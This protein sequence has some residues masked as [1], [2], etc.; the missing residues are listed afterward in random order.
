MKHKIAWW[1]TRLTPTDL[2]DPAT[3]EPLYVY[4][5][6]RPRWYWHWKRF[7]LFAAI[8]WRKW[9]DVRLTAKMAW[10]IAAGVYSDKIQQTP[11]KGAGR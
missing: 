6:I 7:T 4:A 11:T 10:D 8:V 1:T 5:K 9:E 3:N 2:Y